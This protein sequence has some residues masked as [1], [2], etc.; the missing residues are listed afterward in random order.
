MLLVGRHPLGRQNPT[1]ARISQGHTRQ[2]TNIVRDGCACPHCSRFPLSEIPRRSTAAD[3]GRVVPTFRFLWVIRDD[4]TAPGWTATRPMALELID[5]KSLKF[6]KKPRAVFQGYM[7]IFQKQCNHYRR[8]K[9][10]RLFTHGCPGVLRT[11]LDVDNVRVLAVDHEHS[12]PDDTSA[13]NDLKMQLVINDS[14][15]TQ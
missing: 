14:M 3:P 13:I 5:T 10:C 12:H 6:H 7:Y 4:T 11:S 9:C 15:G 8:W 2:P 1:H